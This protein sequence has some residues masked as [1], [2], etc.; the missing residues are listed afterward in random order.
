MSD[1]KV[2]TISGLAMLSL[3]IGYNSTGDQPELDKNDRPYRVL[4]HQGTAFTVSEDIF[5]SWKKG[6]L[7]SIQV[8]ESTRKIE[9]PLDAT[10]EISV[11]SYDNATGVTYAQYKA[12][13]RFEVEDKLLEQSI[14]ADLTAKAKDLKLETF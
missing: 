13:R 3:A 8:T 7:H 12:L 9:D 2:L 4:V 14:M 6:E 10:K 5:Q 1:K 11:P